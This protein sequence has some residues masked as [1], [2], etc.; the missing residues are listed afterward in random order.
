[1]EKEATP[2]TQQWVSYDLSAIL[3]SW[4][5][6]CGR[7]IVQT[8]INPV[9]YCIWGVLSANVYHGRIITDL[10]QLKAAIEEEW[11][12]FPQVT[13][14]RAIEQYTEILRQSVHEKGGHIDKFH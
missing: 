7:Q 3:R 4:N 2:L 5:P 6:T 1:M 8:L 9:D 11:A 14:N 10:D 12:K 13:I